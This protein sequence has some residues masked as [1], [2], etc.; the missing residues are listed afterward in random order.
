MKSIPEIGPVAAEF[1][2]FVIVAV[3]VSASV[4]PLPRVLS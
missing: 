2:L 1:P 3:S 4:A